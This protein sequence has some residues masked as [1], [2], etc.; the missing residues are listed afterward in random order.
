MEAS[1]SV[2][3]ALTNPT[4][5]ESDE[6]MLSLQQKGW[7]VFDAV[8]AGIRKPDE[9]WVVKNPR[10]CSLSIGVFEDR[11]T[12]W[13]REAI[14][15]RIV[16]Q[17]LLPD[18]SI[19]KQVGPPERHTHLNDETCAICLEP[20][21]RREY[22]RQLACGHCFHKKCIDKYYRKN[23]VVNCPFCRRDYLKDH[24]QSCLREP[25]QQERITYTHEYPI[26]YIVFAGKSSSARDVNEPQAERDNNQNQANIQ[27][28]VRGEEN[29]P[30]RSTSGEVVDDHN[31]SVNRLLE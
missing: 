7:A 27:D 30:Q 23:T 3:Q 11:Q 18:I 10:A 12:A 8:C 16:L 19:M 29:I 24:L 1:S 13:V 15:L 26:W 22:F 25:S 6:M 4:H 17:E 5:E 14:P 2:S 9:L 28:S 20:Y 21:C 31:E